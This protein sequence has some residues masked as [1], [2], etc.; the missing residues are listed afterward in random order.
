MRIYKMNIPQ[1]IQHISEIITN[2]STLH[3]DARTK[4]EY[5]RSKKINKLINMYHEVRNTVETMPCTLNADCSLSYVPDNIIL[6]DY[7]QESFTDILTSG[8]VEE[9]EPA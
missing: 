5:L 7:L 4:G 9:L 2:L 1:H 6:R 3:D 8:L